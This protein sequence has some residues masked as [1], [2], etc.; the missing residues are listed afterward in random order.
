[1]LGESS[2]H[3]ATI[4]PI[5]ETPSRTEGEKDDMITEETVSKTA[6]VEKEPVQEPQDTE[7]IPITIVRPTVTHPETKIIG[8]S[9]RPQL[10]DPIVE[11]QVPQPES[12]S[13]TTP[14]PDRGKGIARDIDESQ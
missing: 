2:A 9:S 8:S 14:K 4:S 10:T 13:H 5:E 6:D 1:M 3:T 12:P 7:P 11:V